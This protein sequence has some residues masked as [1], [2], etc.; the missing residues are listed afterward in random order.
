MKVILQYYEI[1]KEITCFIA[2][3]YLNLNFAQLYLMIQC[4]SINKT[5]IQYTL[6]LRVCQLTP[7]LSPQFVF[8]G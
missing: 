7:L 3:K 4:T 8:H 5:N 2:S 6:S 1:F